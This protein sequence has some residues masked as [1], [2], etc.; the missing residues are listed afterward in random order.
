MNMRKAIVLVVSIPY[1]FI[2][3]LTEA[4]CSLPQQLMSYLFM[5]FGWIF[6]SF[7]AYKEKK[8]KEYFGGKIEKISRICYYK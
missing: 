3:A 8:L 1:A 4:F 2:I 5:L 7:T 6:F